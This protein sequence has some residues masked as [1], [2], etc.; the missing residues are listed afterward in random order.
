MLAGRSHGSGCKLAGACHGCSCGGCDGSDAC[1]ARPCDHDSY[2]CF[3]CNSRTCTSICRSA[4]CCADNACS[5]A[6]DAIC[7]CAGPGTGACGGGG[8]P[9]VAA[10]DAASRVKAGPAAA[11]AF[12]APSGCQWRDSGA[13]SSLERSRRS[14]KKT[15]AIIPFSVASSAAIPAQQAQRDAFTAGTEREAHGMTPSVRQNRTPILASYRYLTTTHLPSASSTLARTALTW[16]GGEG[17]GISP[18]SRRG[19]PPPRW[20]QQHSDYPWPAPPR[21]GRAGPRRSMQLPRVSRRRH[22]Q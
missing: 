2:S 16:Q 5:T 8:A 6:I 19:A 18:P 1:R 17:H 3:C 12:A 10:G 15:S 7:V 21:S 9:A 11:A 20:R 13:C 22:V 4:S 14:S